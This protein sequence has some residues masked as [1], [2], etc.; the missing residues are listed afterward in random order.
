MGPQIETTR[1]I[2]TRPQPT[3][4]IQPYVATKSKYDVNLT[5]TLNA[6]VT[7]IQLALVRL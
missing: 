7:I 4:V 2:T 1:S 5:I 3:S 6:V